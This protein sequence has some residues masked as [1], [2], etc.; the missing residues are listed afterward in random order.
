MLYTHANETGLHNDKHTGILTKKSHSGKE[1]MLY[2]HMKLTHTMTNTL[3]HHCTGRKRSCATTK[4]TVRKKIC[5]A[6]D[7]STDLSVIKSDFKCNNWILN[8][9]HMVR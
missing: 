6:G 1:D 9:T 7:P 2:T 8:V 4:L 3:R 5:R